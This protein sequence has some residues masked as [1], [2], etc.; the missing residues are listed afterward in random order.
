MKKQVHPSIQEFKEFVKKHPTLVQE[1]RSGKKNWQ[2]LYEDWYLLGEADEKW[3]IYK[4][5]KE[6]SSPEVK[7]DFMG[8][9]F[10]TI[11][12]VNINDVQEQISNVG[13]A[14]STIQDVIHQFQTFKKPSSSNLNQ[15][16]NHPFSFRKD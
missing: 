16:H 6:T 12:N 9:I 3:K 1:V 7:E 11:K 15:A 5:S 14:I 8:R 13:T 4:G 10:S 2:E